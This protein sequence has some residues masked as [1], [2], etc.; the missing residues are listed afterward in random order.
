MKIITVINGNVHLYVIHPL[1]QPDY[2]EETI[3]HLENN[4]EPNENDEECEVRD[5]DSLEDLNN[6]VKCTFEDFDTFKDLNNLSDKFDEG[7]TTG[8]ED[9]VDQEDSCDN[10]NL[11]RTTEGIDQ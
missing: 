1:S 9:A 11:E 3:L 7:G 6:G 8:I 5:K 2:I 4:V 10:V